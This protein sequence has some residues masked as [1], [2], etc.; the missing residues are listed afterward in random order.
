[1]QLERNVKLD[2]VGDV[3]AWLQSD[4]AQWQADIEGLKR[5]GESMEHEIVMLEKWIQNFTRVCGANPAEFVL[6]KRNE[7]AQVG[8]EKVVF[9]GIHHMGWIYVQHGWALQ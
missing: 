8:D 4:L 5:A 1:M 3:V 7:L 9:C 2:S 6:L